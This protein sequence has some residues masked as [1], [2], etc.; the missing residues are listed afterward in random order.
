MEMNGN[1]N[2]RP[3]TFDQ[4]DVKPADSATRA[5]WVKPTLE[6]LSL[7]EALTGSFH[8]LDGPDGSSS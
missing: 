5:A 3:E 4:A 8:H 1:G 7:K 2:M 6:R